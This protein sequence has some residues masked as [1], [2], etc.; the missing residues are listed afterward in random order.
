MEK[1]ILSANP[2][3]FNHKLAFKTNGY[4]DWKQT[5]NYQVGD[6][7]YIYVTKPVAKISFK[8]QVEKI[9]QDRE[10][11]TDMSEFWIKN[12]D[13]S[14]KRFV[15]LKLICE[16]EDEMLSFEHLQMN[17]MK[18]APQSPCKVKEELQKYLDKLEAK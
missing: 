18:Y 14:T 16:Y 2:N 4:I 17:G 6:I 9:D 1:W 13:K 8:T 7:V 12:E 15:R 10:A 3:Y 5:R 11:I